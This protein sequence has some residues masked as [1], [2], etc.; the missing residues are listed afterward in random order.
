MDLPYWQERGWRLPVAD[1]HAGI[2]PQVP[3]QSHLLDTGHRRCLLA[4][5]LQQLIQL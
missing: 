3:C 1:Q 4:G 2:Q 5:G